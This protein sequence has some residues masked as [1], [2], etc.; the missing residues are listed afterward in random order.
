MGK[1]VVP[2]L[3]PKNSALFSTHVGCVQVNVNETTFMASVESLAH[4]IVVLSVALT[5][6]S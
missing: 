6:V 3:T 5:V 1:L 4:P 2:R